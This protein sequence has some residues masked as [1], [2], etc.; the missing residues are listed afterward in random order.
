VIISVILAYSRAPV[1]IHIIAPPVLLRV[2]SACWW[3][4]GDLKQVLNYIP[5]S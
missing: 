5:K 3:D 1:Q 4:G 2:P